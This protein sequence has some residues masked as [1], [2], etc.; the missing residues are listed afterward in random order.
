[1]ANMFVCA[2]KKRAFCFLWCSTEPKEVPARHERIP[3][4]SKVGYKGEKDRPLSL[5]LRKSQLPFQGSQGKKRHERKRGGNNLTVSTP[6]C[7]NFAFCILHFALKKHPEGCFL[8]KSAVDG[9]R[10]TCD[11]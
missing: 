4:K 8:Y 10:L 2:T 1:M 6:D 9:N 5:L 3:S 11:K 7:R